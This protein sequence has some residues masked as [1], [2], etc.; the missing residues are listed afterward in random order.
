MIV[1]L[2]GGDKESQRRYI[3]R[4]RRIAP[5]CLHSRESVSLLSP[6]ARAYQG[7]AATP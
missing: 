3:A 7:D 5:L 6:I 1:L 2:C 4:A